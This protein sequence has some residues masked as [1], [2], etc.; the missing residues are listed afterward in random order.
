MGH[1]VLSRPFIRGI[2]LVALVILVASVLT[3]AAAWRISGGHWLTVRTASMGPAAP[4]G[5]LV[6]TRPTTVEDVRPGD[7]VSFRSP[8]GSTYTHRVVQVAH[9][10]V[11]TRG[12][13]N[14]TR[15]PYRIQSRDLVGKVVA[16]WRGVGFLLRALPFLVIPGGLLW[17]VTRRVRMPW[18]TASRLLGTSLIVAGV[19]LVQRPLVAAE[20]AS[21]TTVAHG[22]R[23]SVVST[24]LLPVE[25]RPAG[26][27]PAHLRPGELAAV[28]GSHLNDRHELPL[29]VAPHLTGWWWVVVCT[30]CA[31]PFLIGLRLGIRVEPS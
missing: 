27:T 20:V 5:T 2:P 9:G 29:V 22:V 12:D 28:T 16:R 15:D 18:R 31:L 7:I 11:T 17:L 6:I 19:V 26:G 13:N 8:S 14:G 30:G 25:I 4:V 23:A 21:S 3:G 24:G 1:V 10:V